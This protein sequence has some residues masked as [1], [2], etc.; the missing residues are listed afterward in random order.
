[1]NR[2]PLLLLLL[3]VATPVAAQRPWLTTTFWGSHDDQPTNT[4]QARVEFGGY[5][6]PNTTLAFSFEG[7]RQS[8]PGSQGQNSAIGTTTARPGLTG[9]LAIPNARF[10]IAAEVAPLLGAPGGAPVVWSVRPSLGLGRGVSLRARLDH[11]RYT[12]TRAS[13]D[14]TV[15]RTGYELALDRGDAPAWA[16]A[17]RYRRDDHGDDN[18]VTTLSFWILAPLTRSA[19]HSFRAG[20]AFGRQDAAESRWVPRSP[21]GGPAT[22]ELVPGEYQPYYTPHDV[23]VHSVVADAAVA[24]GK[25]WFK[26]NGAIGVHARE[27]VPELRRPPGMGS[28]LLQFVE[29]SFHPWRAGAAVAGPLSDVSSLELRAEYQRTAFWKWLEM[30]LVF[31]RTL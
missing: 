30:R 16:G 4:L 24:A 28:P 12:A 2:L 13:L 14:T 7:A 27:T 3:V 22:G 9:T 26:L 8:A 18:P 21:G 31:A 23:Q 10:G 5:L 11:D 25:A 1:M 19:T 6:N 15:L 20:Y 29:R 17:A